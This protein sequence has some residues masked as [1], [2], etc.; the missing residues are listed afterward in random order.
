MFW[1]AE[2]F[3]FCTLNYC[4]HLPE[5]LSS[6]KGINDPRYGA[7]VKSSSRFLIA[8]MAFLQEIQ[9]ILEETPQLRRIPYLP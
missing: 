1:K 8:R 5:W 6:V 7:G 4:Q 9:F 2:K 3:G